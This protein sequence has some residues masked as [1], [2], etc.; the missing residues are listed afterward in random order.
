MAFNKVGQFIQSIYGRPLPLSTLFDLH[1][2]GCLFPS[3]ASKFLC[4]CF[5]LCCVCVFSTLCVPGGSD[6]L[7]EL[8]HICKHLLSSSRPSLIL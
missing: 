2:Y 6:S 1:L 8:V 5:V 3:I 7:Y 4:L